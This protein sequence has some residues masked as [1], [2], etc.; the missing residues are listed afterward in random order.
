[1]PNG[2]GVFDTGFADQTVSAEE[3]ELKSYRRGENPND[4]LRPVRQ[5]ERMFAEGN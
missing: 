2:A 5:S 4:Y 3:Q 1:M